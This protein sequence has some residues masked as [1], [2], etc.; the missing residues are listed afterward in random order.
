VHT[1][2]HSEHFEHDKTIKKGREVV[3]LAKS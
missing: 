3:L 2:G 1:G